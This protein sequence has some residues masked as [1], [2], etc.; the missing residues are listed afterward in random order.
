ML[1]GL[2]LPEVVSEGE[3]LGSTNGFSE[4]PELGDSE[5]SAEGVTLL[6]E[7]SD[8]ALLG[9]RL[10]LGPSLGDPLGSGFGNSEGFSLGDLDGFVLEGESLADSLNKLGD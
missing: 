9:W 10:P 8:G 3:S 2:G 5:G 4:C 1:E 6:V 7:F